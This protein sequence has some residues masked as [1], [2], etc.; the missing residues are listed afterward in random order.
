[1]RRNTEIRIFVITCIIIFITFVMWWFYLFL[2][3][4]CIVVFVLI[5]WYLKNYKIA[6]LLIFIWLINKKSKLEFYVNTLQQWIKSLTSLQHYLFLYAL[7]ACWII[8]FDEFGLIDTMLN[9]N[10]SRAVPK[11]YFSSTYVYHKAANMAHYLGEE[12]RKDFLWWHRNGINLL[13]LTYEGR[14]CVESMLTHIERRSSLMSVHIELLETYKKSYCF[15]TWS[16]MF[17]DIINSAMIEDFI[18][19]F[20]KF[21]DY[22]FW[23]NKNQLTVNDFNL[24]IQNNIA[25]FVKLDFEFYIKFIQNTK[26]ISIFETPDLNLYVEWLF[27]GGFKKCDIYI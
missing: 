24:V 22:L 16:I 18:H 10:Y 21:H 20:I 26:M 11:N 23:Y 27:R 2:W 17:H 14:M 7:T 4:L 3:M 9:F 12:W 1:M 6:H 8:I 25:I 19:Q 5:I 13:Q 15:K